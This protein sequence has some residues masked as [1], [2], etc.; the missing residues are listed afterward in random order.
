MSP[1]QTLALKTDII[2]KALPGQPLESLVAGNDWQNVAAYYNADSATYVWMPDASR[3]KIVSAIVAKNLTQADLPDGTVIYTNRVLVCQSRQMN[4]DFLL[5][6]TVDTLPGND[7]GFRQSLQ[8]A[9]IDVPAGPGGA[10]LDAGWVAVRNVL[11]RLGTR[12]E[13]MFSVAEGVANESAVYGQRLDG[14]ACYM[15]YTS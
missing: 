2:A 5:P 4:L 13:V 10:L 14:N 15:A 8:D 7:L 12:F 3:S 1:E 11:R 6:P 9:L